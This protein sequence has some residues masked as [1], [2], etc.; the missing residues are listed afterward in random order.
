[1]ALLVLMTSGIFDCYQLAANA[2]FVRAVPYRQR[3]QA[4]G[5]AQGGMNLG[6]GTAMIIAGAVAQHVAPSDVIAATGLLGTVA[7]ISV[8]LLSR[9]RATE[10]D[11]SRPAG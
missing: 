6:Q 8:A 9:N 5:I 2:A 1:V 7:A 10:S 4:F 3:S 11:P